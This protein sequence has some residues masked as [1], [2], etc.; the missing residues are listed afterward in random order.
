MMQS[1]Y[2]HV[3]HVL[4]VALR[5][6][7]TCL[8]AQATLQTLSLLAALRAEVNKTTEAGQRIAGRLE[9]SFQHFRRVQP[10]AP[11]KP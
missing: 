6:L 10:R 4:A 11:E 9:L 1:F 3:P 2:G 5:E 7:S 8:A